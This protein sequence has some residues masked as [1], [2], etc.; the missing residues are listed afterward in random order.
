MEP[1]WSKS[2]PPGGTGV[3]FIIMSLRNILLENQTQAN[4]E[5]GTLE[6]DCQG[7]TKLYQVLARSG[8]QMIDQLAMHTQV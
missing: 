7:V 2:S 4:G 8:W 5:R 6:L 3:S 1:D